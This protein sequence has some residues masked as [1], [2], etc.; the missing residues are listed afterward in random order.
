MS[1]VGTAVKLVGTLLSALPT[2][3]AKKAI[4]GALDIVEDAVEKS[5]KKWDDI[6][7]LPLIALIRRVFDIPDDDD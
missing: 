3:V 6:V 5:E 2:D 1:G 7:V 4:D